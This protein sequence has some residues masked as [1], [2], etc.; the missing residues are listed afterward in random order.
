MPLLDSFG[1]NCCGNYSDNSA[2]RK[3]QQNGYLF[4]NDAVALVTLL[5][6]LNDRSTKAL[7]IRRN[8]SLNSSTHIDAP[9]SI[10]LYNQASNRPDETGE[11]SH[12]IPYSPSKLPTG[13]IT[14][15][16]PTPVGPRSPSF[17]LLSH[18]SF[19]T[20]TRRMYKSHCIQQSEPP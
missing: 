6:K 11:T 3:Y 15:K 9:R 5:I 14:P 20:V 17:A 7:R 16:F 4:I 8:Q 2:R 1:W 13:Q 18:R 12:E 10:S 19:T